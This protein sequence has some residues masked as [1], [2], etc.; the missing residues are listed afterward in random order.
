MKSAAAQG[1]AT[2]VLL[3]SL[4]PAA[5]CAQKPSNDDCLACHG[6]AGLTHEVSGKP[7]SLYVSPEKFK[8][9]LH[10]TIFSC[11]DCHSDVKASMHQTTPEKVS[12]SRCHAQEQSA[13][14]R[15][16]HA[17][18][19]QGGSG[20]SATC[21]DCHGS[22][23]E[24][25]PA[26]D[27]KSKVSHG[28][29]PA[30]CG[31]CHGQKFVMEPK[32]LST[33]PYL[34][35][36]ESVHGRA[37]HAGISKA[38]VCTDCH[39]THEILSASDSTSPIFRFNVPGTCGKCH[40]VAQKEF[41]ASIHG[42]AVARGE[43][44]A[45]VCTDCHGIHAIKS[46]HD[47]NSSVSA[48]N[49]AQ[50]TC[51]RCHESVRLSEEFGLEGRRATT[52][53]ASYHGL[54]SRLGSQVV[55]NCASCHG[56]HN[57]LPSSDP[58]STI[59]HANMITT[60]GQCHPGVT[61][62]F[63][64]GRVHVDRTFSSDRGSI[65]VRWVRNIYLVIIVVV[66]GGMLFHNAVI[67]RRAALA[68]HGRPGEQ[69]LRMTKNQRWQH[70]LLLISFTVL[71]FTGFALKYPESGFAA[72]IGMSERVRGIVHRVAGAALTFAGVYHLIYIGFAREGRRMLRDFIPAR[73]D[74][75]AAWRNLRYH[76]QLSPERP[77]FRRFSYA[78]KIEYW[79]LVWGTIIMALTGI[80]LWAK[81]L[82]ARLLP[83][84]WLD[85][86]T[87]VHFYEAVLATL[88]I[89]VWHLY[90][91]FLDPDAFP[92]NWAWWDG[93]VDGQ[94]YREA[95]SLDP[96]QSVTDASE[97]SKEPKTDEP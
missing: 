3:L 84:W 65:A 57:I 93:K 38:A 8:D 43:G 79:A 39:G 89:L 22:P 56:A 25:L 97:H 88:A 59:N 12:C 24:L 10:G 86:A 41:A 85:L 69:V 15:S 31:T 66:I 28:H 48:L 35:Y 63:I 53:L 36:Q 90:Q 13:Y 61:E 76:L 2:A 94:R 72:F 32:G 4:T 96:E 37:L 40:A 54:A 49:L 5:L 51:A 42:Q 20:P 11:V 75:T 67:W 33:Q 81:V 64:S 45:P 26:S 46:R 50:A 6:D 60:C 80:M 1:F 47:P 82:V 7:V 73:E 62:R 70:W 55:A 29:V 14:E 34:A 18:T 87:A 92:M 78:E 71:V 95:H 77:G 52:Y 58:R 21:G 16:L 68:A 83:R 9:S 91:V 30:T 17:K 27:P 23:H 19:V 74:L 44:Q